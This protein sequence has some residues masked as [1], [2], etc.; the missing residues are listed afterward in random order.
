[1]S[2]APKG[3]ILLADDELSFLKSTAALLA[4]AGY[5]CTTVT[6]GLEAVRCLEEESFDVLIADIHMPGNQELELVREGPLEGIPVILVTGE[7]SLESAIE[8]VKLPVSGYLVK[9][10]RRDDLLKEVSRV[11]EISKM[12]QCLDR[13]KDRLRSWSDDLD[14]VSRH[15]HTAGK[16]GD[17]MTHAVMEST[18]RHVVDALMDFARLS[19]PSGAPA[20]ADAE[21]CRLL[22]CER[23][24]AFVNAVDDT[25]DVLEKTKRSF[26]SKDLGELR[27]R[28]ESLRREQTW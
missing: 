10:V 6:C 8:S 19:A 7:P 27:A 22:K 26:R 14:S 9:P 21:V 11:L 13:G 1:M 5:E 17:A 18:V 20:T 23:L 4:R 16:S 24:R 3:T 12:F 28:L 2:D 15:R 25:I